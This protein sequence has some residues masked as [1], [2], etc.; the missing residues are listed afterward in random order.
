MKKRDDIKAAR[1]WQWQK[2]SCLRLVRGPFTVKEPGLEPRFSIPRHSASIK[3]IRCCIK[4]D[5]SLEAKNKCNGK[6]HSAF[7]ES[8]STIMDL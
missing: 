2:C 4:A 3:N 1:Q 5:Y 8:H 7:I 6:K